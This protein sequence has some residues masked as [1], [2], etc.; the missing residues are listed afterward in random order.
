MCQ[1]LD[2]KRAQTE[3]LWLIDCFGKIF[4]TFN[5]PV[6]IIN[7]EGHFAYYNRA[8]ARMDGVDH[9][10]I[11]GRHIC[12]VTP[13]LNPEDSTLL[14]CISEQS[15]F[16]DY[17]Q[18]YTGI[19]GEK[20][21]YVHNASPLYGTNGK[22]IGAIELGYTLENAPNSLSSHVQPPRIIGEHHLLV[23]Q[24]DALDVFANSMLPILIYGET[25]SG[26]E[27]FA[28]RAHYKSPR[29]GKKM[30]SLNCAAMPENLVESMLFGTIRGAFTGAENKKGLFLLADGGTLF[31]DEINSMPVSLQSKLLRVLQDGT[32]YP[33]GSQKMEHADVRLIV[34]LN[35]SPADAI[36]EGCLREDL[37]YRLSVGVIIVPPLRKR[38]SDI[39]LLA[40][41]FV[42]HHAINLNPKITSIS[43]RAVDILCHYSW[44]GNIRELE[45]VIKRS[46]LLTPDEDILNTLS[47]ITDVHM[48]S[49]ADCKI[50]PSSE[51]STSLRAKLDN[52]ETQLIRAALN[53]HHG[54]ISASARQLG[55]PRTTL[56]TRISRH[57]ITISEYE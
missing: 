17:Y 5:Q 37:Y 53:M 33:L 16:V 6:T 57:K 7:C 36:R 10:Q 54:N 29:A 45:N 38:K 23:E 46:L 35:Q 3:L 2:K 18:A 19:G 9:T 39:K 42:A 26:K 48:R 50:S 44:P 30:L 13:W 51:E 24:I 20:L 47:F 40:Q 14:R 8:S 11:I 43:E 56:L 34:A 12:D 22:V 21:H 4:D 25:G 49:A 31:L 28:L 27:L 32:F 1:D 55:L 52:Y 15:R 41:H